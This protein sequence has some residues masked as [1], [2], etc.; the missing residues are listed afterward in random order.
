M[1]NPPFAGMLLTAIAL[2]FGLMPALA[3]AQESH[4]PHWAYEGEAGPNAWGNLEPDYVACSMGRTQSP[5]DIRTAKLT[6][7]PPLRFDY[8]AV[9]LDIIDNGHTI[10]VNYAPGSTLTVGGKIYTLKQ[11]HFHHPSEEHVR[12]HGY[13]LVAHL[14][15]ADA[16]G[17]LAVVAV[18]FEKGSENAFIESLW[19]NIPSE[20]GKAVAVSGM[21]INVKDLLPPDHGYYTF[22]GSL[23]TPPCSEG[24]TWYVLKNTTSLSPGQVAAFVKLYPLNARPIQALN[25]R[26][27]LESK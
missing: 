22:A 2:C 4:T 19:K 13:D 8:Q 17:H 18:L 27:V 14:V 23:T 6:D 16:A 20:K 3:R 12:G 9:P 5:I 10:Q 1:K 26:K 21:T 25:G 11:F 24:V 15:H 7:L